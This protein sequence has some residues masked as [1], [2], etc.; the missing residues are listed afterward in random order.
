MDP[1]KKNEAMNVKYVFNGIICRILCRSYTVNIVVIYGM[2][3]I[4]AKSDAIS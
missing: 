1:K 2:Y 3:Y 4:E